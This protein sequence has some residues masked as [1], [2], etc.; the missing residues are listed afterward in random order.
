MWLRSTVLITIGLGTALLLGCQPNV[1]DYVS[2]CEFITKSLL[3]SPSGYKK[4]D[5]RNSEVGGK[6]N[7]YLT[8]D[9]PNSYGTDL[10]GWTSCDFS[11][12][13][14]GSISIEKYLSDSG[15]STENALL[16]ISVDLALISWRS[17]NPGT[18]WPIDK[19]DNTD[20]EAV[21]KGRKKITTDAVAPPSVD[22]CVKIENSD[23]RLGCY[24]AAFTRH[25][26][27]SAENDPAQNVKT[28]DVGNWT[29]STTKNPIDD[30]ETVVA[31][32]DGKAGVL[33]K[34]VTF[35]ARCQSKKTEAYINWDN[36][37]G[38]DSDSPYSDWKYVKLRVGNDKAKT[39]SWSTSTDHK[40]TFAVFDTHGMKEALTPLA[41]MCGWSF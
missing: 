5:I 30:T 35:I 10:R 41:E 22:V 27:I 7:V 16:K 14:N 31:M 2:A 21:D 6:A 18:A 20:A 8:Y 12:A 32:L 34:G 19:D 15:D 39:E 25:T 9:A 36:Y 4:V 33:A 11:R 37:L 23:E 38:N 26:N 28:P 3:K 40:A 24:D 17:K 29:I 13:S 1:P